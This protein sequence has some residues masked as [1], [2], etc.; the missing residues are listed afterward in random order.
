MPIFELL[1]NLLLLFGRCFDVLQVAQAAKDPAVMWHFLLHGRLL[2]HSVGLVSCTSSTCVLQMYFLLSLGH[3]SVALGTDR[4][5][6][7]CRLQWGT[8]HLQSPQITAPEA[9]LIH[10]AC[11]R[12]P[13]NAG[14]I[15]CRLVEV[16]A[17]WSTDELK[18][19][20]QLS[21]AKGL[22]SSCGGAGEGEQAER[23]V[24]EMWRRHD[25][26]LYLQEVAEADLK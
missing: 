2:L 7:L 12:C 6:W 25:V 21:P 17:P 11:L 5:G 16:K 20:H 8:V 19:V 18:S 10:N 15:A 22:W 1:L 9:T 4:A 24:E 13:P 14:A 3:V 26:Y 23:Q